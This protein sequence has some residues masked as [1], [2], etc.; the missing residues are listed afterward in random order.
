MAFNNTGKI[1]LNYC[2]LQGT[3]G[4]NCKSPSE[5]IIDSEFN[6]KKF[7]V[8]CKDYISQINENEYYFTDFKM[9]LYENSFEI[10]PK[11]NQK[12][13]PI[14]IIISKI[15]TEV[16][17]E[18]LRKINHYDKSIKENDIK[19]VVTVPAIWDDKSNR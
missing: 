5:I 7:G 16:K 18:A 12:K 4:R 8:H 9:H 6:T 1:E 15:L 14:I 2:G 3:E 10:Q 11:N 17:L 19:L 13:F